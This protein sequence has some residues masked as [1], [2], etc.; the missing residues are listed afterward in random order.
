MA[1]PDMHGDGGVVPEGHA[2]PRR[3]KKEQTRTG[4]HTSKVMA[5]PVGGTLAEKGR[6]CS[7]DILKRTKRYRVTEIMF[8]GR[9]LIFFSPLRDS[10]SKAT[11]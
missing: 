7:S 9:G 6:E 2:T 4:E 8:C 5:S 3:V 10:N 11:H 1:S